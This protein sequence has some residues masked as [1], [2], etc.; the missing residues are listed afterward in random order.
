LSA[1]LAFQLKDDLMDID[2]DSNKGHKLGSDI[3]GGK[4]TLLVIKTME[5]GDGKSGFAKSCKIEHLGRAVWIVP[6][7]ALVAILLF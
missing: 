7:N 4:N 3:K 2:P 6:I 1:A 5:L